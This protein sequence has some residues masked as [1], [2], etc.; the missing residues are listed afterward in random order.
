M[1]GSSPVAQYTYDAFGQRVMK[2]GAVSG[3]TFYQYDPSCHL[4]EETDGQGN[5]GGLHLSADCLDT[6]PTVDAKARRN[7]KSG[8]WRS[9][10]RVRLAAGRGMA[11]DM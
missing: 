7:P 9:H 4:L 11:S 1:A 10:G 6:A 2:M 8:C 5:A 3:T